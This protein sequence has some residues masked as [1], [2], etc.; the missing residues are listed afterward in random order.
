[1]KLA[2]PLGGYVFLLIKFVIAI[3][4]GHQVLISTELFG[5]LTAGFR[6]DQSFCYRDI[7]FKF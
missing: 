2:K 1:M 4:V 7:T 6:E 3:F 5:I